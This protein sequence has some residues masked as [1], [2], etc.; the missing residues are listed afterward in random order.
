[1]K[2]FIYLLAVAAIVAAGL[3][4]QTNVGKRGVSLF[5]A[6]G[7]FG[8]FRSISENRGNFQTDNNTFVFK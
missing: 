6:P 7:E 3:F 1:M 8:C 5:P 4:F 2:K